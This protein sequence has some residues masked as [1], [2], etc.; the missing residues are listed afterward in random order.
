MNKWIPVRP[1]QIN[2]PRTMNIGGIEST[3]F[4]SPYDVPDGLRGRYDH[5]KGT[6]SID[7]RYM[8]SE[9][10]L[11]RVEERRIDEE[12]VALVGRISGRLY[13]IT[14]TLDAIGIP[15]RTSAARTEVGAAISRL[16]NSHFHPM[17][18]DNYEVSRQA[19]L[20]RLDDD[21]FSKLCH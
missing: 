14:V 7:F 5:E 8:G 20:D 15:V 4:L 19:I 13:R 9:E 18:V 1:R 3:V 2:L 11:E 12:T 21:W 6:F 10:P 16:A 17:K